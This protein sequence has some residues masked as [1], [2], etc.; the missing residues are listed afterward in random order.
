MIGTANSAILDPAKDKVGAAVRAFPVEKSD[1]AEIV[2]EEDEILAHQ[3]NGKRRAARRKRGN[4][5][6]RL[7]VADAHRG[8]LPLKEVECLRW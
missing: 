7:P 4:K 8:V 1:D 6:N 5:R 3:P 2:A